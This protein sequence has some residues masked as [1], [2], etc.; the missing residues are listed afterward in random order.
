MKFRV[1]EALDAAYHAA[2]DR[3][4]SEGRADWLARTLVWAGYHLC[5]AYERELT[6]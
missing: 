6:R 5:N 3:Y 2:T 1:L 4:L